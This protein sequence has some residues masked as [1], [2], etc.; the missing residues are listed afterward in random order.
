M[1]KQ[2]AESGGVVVN[3][4]SIA[5]RAEIQEA[6]YEFP[7]HHIPNLGNDGSVSLSRRMAWGLEYLCYQNHVVDVVTKMKPNSVLEVGCGDGR[8]LGTLPSSIPIRIGVDLSERA[9][10]FA[11]AF[12]PH[13]TFHAAD[14]ATLDNKFDVITAIEVL[15]HIPDGMVPNFLNV[16]AQKMKDDGYFIIT[17][18]TVVLPLNPKHFRHY[19]VDVLR[20]Q[21]AAANSPMRIEKVEYVYSKPMWFPLMRRLFDNRFFSL[22]VKPF[23]RWAWKRVWNSHRYADEKTG[24]HMVAYL[25]LGS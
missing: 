22:E 16:V 2:R 18:P 23:M 8:F 12:H 15:E 14:V 17:V 1:M 20:G 4:G 24:F 10:S 7:Y 21:L 6:Q 19:T 11:K 5:Q 25:R 9:I 3:S 13:C